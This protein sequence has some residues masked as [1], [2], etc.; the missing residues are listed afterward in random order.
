MGVRGREGRGC[1]DDGMDVRSLRESKWEGLG[2]AVYVTLGCRAGVC[3]H[4]HLR[5]T[6]YV[7]TTPYNCTLTLYLMK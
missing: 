7:Q 5:K 6:Y 1:I 4:A 3:L 2:K